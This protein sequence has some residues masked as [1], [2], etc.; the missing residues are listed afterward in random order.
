LFSPTQGQART[1]HF[2]LTKRLSTKELPLF[3]F[4]FR[5]QEVS[6]NGHFFSLQGG[7]FFYIP[8][9]PNDLSSFRV[10]LF[11]SRNLF[12]QR[13]CRPFWWTLP[14]PR[15]ARRPGFSPLAAGFF[16]S[17]FVSAVFLFVC[18]PQG[19]GCPDFFPLPQFFLPST[20]FRPPEGFPVPLVTFF[21]FFRS[22]K[23]RFPSRRTFRVYFFILLFLGHTGFSL[24]LLR[25]IFFFCFGLIAGRGFP[26]RFPFHS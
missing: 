18:F 13:P 1:V 7:G 5:K 20:G 9:S 6:I 22:R 26:D 25:R 11:P 19:R 23:W 17:P 21:P 3:L 8:E 10:G 4:L 16:W 2:P 12:F 24:F 14:L 15:L